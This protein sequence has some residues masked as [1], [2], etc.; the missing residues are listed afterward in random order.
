MHQ[1]EALHGDHFFTIKNGGENL[2]KEKGSKFFAFAYHVNSVE[3]AQDKVN[4]LRI[5]YHDA[6]HY[7]Y[8]YRINPEK[9][10]VRANDD[11]EPS[12]SAGT[13]IY[14]QLLSLDLWNT[15]VV[16]V[17]YFGGT[18]L[19]VS[20]LTN[21]YKTAAAG[22]LANSDIIE[23]F[24][25]EIIQ[26]TFPYS[27]TN[28]VMRLIKDEDAEILEEQMGLQGGYKL[29]IRKSHFQTFKEKLSYY[30]LIDFM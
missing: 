30:H 6:R 9:P 18:K 26:I 27:L 22:T 1:E 19:G 25:K 23:S 15:L 5:K 4:E 7:C 12:N 16:V 10:E 13:P 2:Y 14:N 17:R 24:L 8:A 3:E 21:A 11:G 29:A 28:E 20:G